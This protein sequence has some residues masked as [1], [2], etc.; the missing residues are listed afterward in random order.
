[1]N[2]M[3]KTVQFIKRCKGD[4]LPI[5]KPFLMQYSRLYHSNWPHYS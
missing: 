2:I 1:M 4:M 3:L 5:E